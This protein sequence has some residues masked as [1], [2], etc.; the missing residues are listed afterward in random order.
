MVDDKLGW[1]LTPLVDESASTAHTVAFFEGLF[2]AFLWSSSY[3]LVK[4]GLQS[5]HALPFAG[6]R[7]MLAVPMLVVVMYYRD[8]LASVYELSRYE[9]VQLFVLGVLWYA[10]TPGTQYLGLD[11]LPATTVSM[12]LSLAPMVVALSSGVTLDERVSPLQWGG[13]G[14][15]LVG[16]GIYFVPFS[17]PQAKLIGIVIV[18]ASVFVNAASTILGRHVNRDG[19]IPSITVTVVSMFVGGVLLMTTGTAIHGIPDF[20]PM[21]WAITFVLAF[22]NTAIAFT[23]WNHALRELSAAEAGLVLSTITLQVAV[24]DWLVF[25]ETLLLKEAVGLGI[26]LLGILAVHV[27]EG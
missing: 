20:G 24:L 11:L 26:A 14:F 25:G 16:V 18:L 22:F 8:V 3:I 1:K 6:L 27:Y 4:I 12:L 2:V 15:Y 23:M 21:S 17:F 7:F 13:I 5:V 19:A 9:W 10:L